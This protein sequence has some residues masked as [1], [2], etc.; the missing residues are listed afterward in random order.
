M[1]LPPFLAKPANPTQE[2]ASLQPPFKWGHSFHWM[3]GH[4]DIKN[5]D[6]VWP[7]VHQCEQ[8]LSPSAL[9]HYPCNRSGLA[10]RSSKEF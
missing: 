10:K 2:Y 1:W 7:A 8:F 6:S 4:P 5:V 9:L 3:F